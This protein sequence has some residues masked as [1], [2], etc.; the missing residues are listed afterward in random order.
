MNNKPIMLLQTINNSCNN[1]IS[2]TKPFEETT[3]SPLNST[4][5]QLWHHYFSNSK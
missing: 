5:H 3:V 4:G 1:I 2:Y